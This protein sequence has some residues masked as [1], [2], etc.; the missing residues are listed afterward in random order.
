M[1]RR[2]VAA[3]AVALLLGAPVASAEI[4]TQDLSH[5]EAV[6]LINELV[7][8]ALDPRLGSWTYKTIGRYLIAHTRSIPGHGL[9]PLHVQAG[10][11]V[12]IA[13]SRTQETEYGLCALSWVYVYIS[14]HV[15]TVEPRGFGICLGVDG[16]VRLSF[17]GP[18]E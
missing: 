16:R 13:K 14:P 8:N 18:D 9:L 11:Q 7:P 12:Q 4:I 1:G 6:A 17:S 2:L 5:D 3:L 10:I 15:G